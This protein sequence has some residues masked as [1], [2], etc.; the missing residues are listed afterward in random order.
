MFEWGCHADGFGSSGGAVWR[1]VWVKTTVWLL[2]QSIC[3]VKV[4]SARFHLYHIVTGSGV[5]WLVISG[6]SVT[7]WLGVLSIGDL[8]V[9]K[10]D[11]W[12]LMRCDITPLWCPFETSTPWSKTGHGDAA[13]IDQS[14]SLTEQKMC[15]YHNIK[16]MLDGLGHITSWI[17]TLHLHWYLI[18]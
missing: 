18:N 16:K 15:I 14:S 11:H 4:N 1:V 8:C 17:F 3:C 2:N 9:R 12:I 13:F 6:E 7:D 10:W 5:G